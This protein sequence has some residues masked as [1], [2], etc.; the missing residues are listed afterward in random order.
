[1]GPGALI[2]RS[3]H[4]NDGAR[5]IMPKILVENY[6]DKTL[7]LG[8]EPWAGLEKMEPDGQVTFEYDEPAIIEVAFMNDGSASIVVCAD[9]VKVS[10]NGTETI[11]EMPEGFSVENFLM[12]KK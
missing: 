12:G 5:G 10:A 1:M 3:A 4:D 2:R 11:Y 7:N 6:T 9:N 8:I